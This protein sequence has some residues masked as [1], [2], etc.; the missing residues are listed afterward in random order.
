MSNHQVV[1]GDLVIHAF[2]RQELLDKGRDVVSG[3]GCIIVA[4]DVLEMHIF[5]VVDADGEVVGFIHLLL[6]AGEVEVSL[7]EVSVVEDREEQALKRYFEDSTPQELLG[8]G[9]LILVC[10]K[11]PDNYS[12]FLF[13]I[14]SVLLRQ[15]AFVHLG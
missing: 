1:L 6:S 7:K 13:N 9:P 10:H 3:V 11:I 2:G 4:V 5:K 14:L 8:V 12:A 15:H